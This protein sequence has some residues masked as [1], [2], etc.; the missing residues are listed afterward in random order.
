M[1]NHF[2]FLFATVSF[3]LPIGS[4]TW[5]ELRFGRIEPN[6]VKYERGGMT[7][8]VCESG[9]P[10]V[11][12]HER[13]LRIRRVTVTGTVVGELKVPIDQPKA[14]RF[15]DAL[16]RVGIITAGE[17]RLSGLQKRLA[18][19]WL[20]QLDALVAKGNAGIGEIRSGLLV[21]FSEWVGESRINPKFDIFRDIIAD[22]PELGGK[23]RITVELPDAPTTVGLWL[24]A[25]GDDS[26]S[27]FQIHIDQ[28]LVEEPDIE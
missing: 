16:L 2:H 25:D 7:I 1:M 15:D 26:A 20:R 6:K 24:Q 28:I 8:S 12:I 14:A 22:A 13:P 18:P 21:P 11:R 5:Q 19:E 27:T 10:L 9:S 4:E 17:Q 3:L 23:F